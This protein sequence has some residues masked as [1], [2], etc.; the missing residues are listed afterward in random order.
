MRGARSGL[1]AMLAA[2][3]WA[4]QPAPHTGYVY[5][6]GGRQA[7]SFQVTVGGQALVGASRA[8]ISGAGVEAE[9]VEY[10]RPMTAAEFQKLRDELA[11][12]LKKEAVA[13]GP[14]GPRIAELRKKVA[15][16]IRRPAQP[17]IAETVTLKVTIAPDAAAGQ[18][19]L[20]LVARTG[21]TNPL[22]FRVDQ[23]P[24]FSRA[25]IKVVTEPGSGL[26]ARWREPPQNRAAEPPMEIT[27]PAILN[28]QVGPGMANRYRLRATRGQR[29]VAEVRARELIPYISDAVPGWFQAALT[30]RDGAGKEVAA[31]GSHR[32]RPDPVLF[33]EAPGD[34]DYVLEIRDAIYRGRE[35]FVYRISVGELPYLTGVFPLGGKAGSRTTV[36]L[37]GWNLP[38]SRLTLRPLEAGVQEVFVEQDG[39]TSNRLPFLAGAL[40]EVRETEPNDEPRQAR[41]LKLPALVNGRIERP[42]ERDVFRIDGRAGQEMVA[43]VQARRLES[44][45]D[46]VLRLMDS[47]GRELASNDDAED[48]GA[49]L[50][51]HHADSRLLFTLPRKGTYYLQLGDN[52]GQGGAEYAY[53]LRIGA[54]QPDFELRVTPASLT[55]GWGASA[56][57]AVYALR[58]DGFQGEI[59]LRLKDAPAG[60]SIS[61]GRVPAGLE[62]VRLTLSAPPGRAGEH[63]RLTLEGHAVIRG[64]EVRRMAVPAEDMTQA[65]AYHHLVPAADWMVGLAVAGRAAIPWKVSPDRPV[66]LAPGGTAAVRVSVPARR[67]AG[68]ME[69]ALNGPPEGIALERVTPLPGGVEILLRAEAGKVKPGLK[70]NLILDA[71][72]VPAAG[73]PGRPRRQ[74]LGV[75]PAVPFEVAPR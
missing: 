11:E 62:Q 52:Q 67:P 70:G 15:A 30:L 8:L 73:A 13:G 65:F 72:F 37:L 75:L 36:E 2:A 45:L 10:T 49:G 26:P 3:A 54:P 7:T 27:L 43:E 21:L 1:A 44:P 42:G 60:F 25:P 47:N 57:F 4:Q 74:A 16:F 40:A 61:G 41:K 14:D 24:E 48:A 39:R 66:Q 28:G 59:A 5:P 18:R 35:D 68:Q 63:F 19:E 34:G 55:P 23:L 33:F 6:A 29:L 69:F 32:F 20:R 31:A 51:T 58:R 53:R 22:A 9:V 12:L 56:P 46:S 64:R 50:L 17:A 38:V 71:F